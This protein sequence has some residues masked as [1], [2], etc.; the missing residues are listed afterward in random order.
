MLLSLCIGFDSFISV[1][2]LLLVAATFSTGMCGVEEKLD[3]TNRTLFP[4]D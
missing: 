2:F 3:S 4:Y 1:S